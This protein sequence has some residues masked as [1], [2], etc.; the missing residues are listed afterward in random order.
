MSKENS[1]TKSSYNHL[2][3]IER[4]KIEALHKQ[5]KSQTEIARLM[6]R[7]RSTISRELKRGTV[8]QMKIKNEKLIY[9]KEYFA[10]TGQEDYKNKRKKSYYL[11]LNKTS[12]R[13]LTNF[14]KEMKEEVRIHSVESFVKRYEKECEEEVI[15]STKTLYN[16]IHQGLLEV[17]PIDLP[18][19]TRMK[20]RTKKRPSTHKRLAGKSID[21]RPKIIQD[22]TEFGHWEIDLMIGK[23][24]INEAVLLTIVER[25]S[26]FAIARKL[27]FKSAD[28]VNHEI[29]KVVKGFSNLDF[30]TITA[31]NG[32]EFSKLGELKCV[33][34]VF[35][36]HPYSSHER[37]TNEH[38]NGL[39]REFLP[40]G[41]SF[42]SLTEEELQR[43]VAAINNRPRK[44]L[45]FLSATE[46]LEQLLAG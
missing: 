17:K 2:S 41:Q 21:E 44:L 38:F 13:F 9:Y 7:N 26:R 16:Y 46:L 35:Y 27:P 28:L 22:R 18:R 32:A 29:N 40:K 43:Y 36:A 1:T 25:V 37:G 5:G 6:G 33:E 15:L 24:F 3:A 42:N 23:K 19:A 12:K 10:E 20:Q 11:K 34:D 14:T 31:D 4:G 8:T 30:K 45:G 39:M